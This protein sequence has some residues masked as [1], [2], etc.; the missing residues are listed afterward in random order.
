M[1]VAV[2]LP[3]EHGAA[4]EHVHHV[5]RHCGGVRTARRGRSAARLWRLPARAPTPASAAG[6]VA[7]AASSRVAAPASFVSP[8]VVSVWNPSP[9]QAAAA[10][11]AAGRVER[12]AQRQHVELVRVGRIVPAAPEVESVAPLHS[13][14]CEAPARQ[15]EHLPPTR[16]RMAVTMREQVELGQRL[17]TVLYA[18]RPARRRRAEPRLASQHGHR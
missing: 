9:N 2:G 7:A 5:A 15:A 16:R 17:R 14:V 1:V 10:A 12:H 13:A 3:L 4:S 18:G 6:S 11:V 8:P